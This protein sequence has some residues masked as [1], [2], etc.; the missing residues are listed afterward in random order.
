MI[1]SLITELEQRCPGCRFTVEAEPP[2]VCIVEY[3]RRFTADLNKLGET[4]EEW[5]RAEI[6]R[7][8]VSDIL[9]LQPDEKYRVICSWCGPV[10]LGYGKYRD[11]LTKPNI[12]WFC[13]ICGGLAKFDSETYENYPGEDV[14]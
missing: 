5:L 14:T 7:H 4:A 13:P 12:S 3:G 11:Q 9:P 6:E 8:P 10:V 2:K 1:D